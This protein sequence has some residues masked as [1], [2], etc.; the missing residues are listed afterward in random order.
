MPTTKMKK[1][2][3]QDLPAGKP[4]TMASGRIKKK[5]VQQ[6]SRVG[7]KPSA[8]RVQAKAPAAGGRKAGASSASATP[9]RRAALTRRRIAGRSASAAR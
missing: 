1:R 3:L 9:A 6:A 7:K 4:G 5:A 8:M 2:A